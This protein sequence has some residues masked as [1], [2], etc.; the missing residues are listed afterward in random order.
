LALFRQYRAAGQIVWFPEYTIKM[1]GWEGGA[2][3]KALTVILAIAI[4]G[5]IGTLIYTV[6]FPKIGERFSEFYILG[7]NGK[8]ELYPNQFKLQN[9]Q[10]STVQYGAGGSQVNESFGR[11][12]IGVINQEQ[13]P[14]SYT[15][16]IAI[17]GQQS[18]VIYDGQ[19]MD[20][21]TDIKLDQGQK[22]EHEIGFAPQ[23]AGENQKVEFFLTKEPSAQAQYSL[24]LW[25][26]V[27]GQ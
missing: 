26:T 1:P 13:Q 17:N 21:L 10:I 12:T 15:I 18:P 8:A 24:H 20:R 3:N 4:L 11:L 6:A 9:G 23:Q 14:A 5:A 7:Q 27:T 19:K 25:A 22:W 2:L 16:S